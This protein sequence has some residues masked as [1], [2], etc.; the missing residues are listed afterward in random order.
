M[1]NYYLVEYLTGKGRKTRVVPAVNPQG[2]ADFVR[3]VLKAT[4]VVA[5]ALMVTDWM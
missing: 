5:V 4:D 2:A 3:V 1:K